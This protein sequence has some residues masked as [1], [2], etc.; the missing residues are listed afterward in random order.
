MYK[1]T[2]REIDQFILEQTKLCLRCLRF[3]LCSKQGEVLTKG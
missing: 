1:C 2:I 3:A